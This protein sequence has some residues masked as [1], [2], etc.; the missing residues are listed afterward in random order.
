MI[1]SC[2]FYMESEM[3]FRIIATTAFFCLFF[4]FFFF[5]R[6]YLPHVEIPRIRATAAG[7]SHGHSNADLV[8]PD[9]SWQQWHSYGK[10][11]LFTILS[12][13]FCDSCLAPGL[14]G[15]VIP[16]GSWVPLPM[17]PQPYCCHHHLWVN[18]EHS[19]GLYWHGALQARAFHLF[20]PS[21]SQSDLEMALQLGCYKKEGPQQIY[22]PECLILSLQ[23]VN[24]L[25][26]GQTLGL[27]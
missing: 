1:R 20:L 11:W 21:W 13:M 9:P 27:G 14:S 22:Y 3:I 4:F 7:L 19:W 6:P 23:W 26:R 18:E 10:L 2:Q 5:L 17:E 24:S 15:W 16:Q 8:M 12:S 25:W